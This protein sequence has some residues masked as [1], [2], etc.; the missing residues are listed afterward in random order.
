MARKKRRRGSKSKDV[1]L[2]PLQSVSLLHELM[3]EL[4]FVLLTQ[5]LTPKS[6]GD[7]ARAAFVEAAATHSRLLNGRVNQSRVAAQTGLSRADVKR[8]LARRSDECN[9][10]LRLTPVE[11]VIGGWRND[12]RFQDAKGAPKPLPISG[13]AESF[14]LL[15]KK[16]A[17]DVPYRAVLGELERINA[18]R[19]KGDRVNLTK[20]TGLRRRED[21]TA[22]T[23]VVPALIDGLR[24]ASA[25]GD[26]AGKSV[27]R[28][29]IP[30]QSELELAFVKDRCSSSAKSMLDGL[31][32]SLGVDSHKLRSKKKGATLVSV[33]ILLSASRLKTRDLGTAGSRRKP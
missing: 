26:D 16:Y 11:R 22:L 9:L 30:A 27:Y 28:L 13:C 10:P 31:G 2:N 25:P 24:I 33:S 8:L 15:A 29:Q 32:H 14:T 21:A 23:A 7:L 17:G 6:F 19:V 3:R 12:R 1:L 20:S 4:A 5:G 18:V